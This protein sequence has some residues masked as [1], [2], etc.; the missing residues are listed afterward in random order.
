MS[1]PD[2]C[3]MDGI[4]PLV[5]NEWLNQALAPLVKDLIEDSREYGEDWLD[6]REWISYLRKDLAQLLQTEAA[7]V[8]ESH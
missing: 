8:R 5:T 3:T 7:A 2:F 6:E 4:T 1:N